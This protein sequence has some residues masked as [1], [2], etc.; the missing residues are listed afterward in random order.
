MSKR[1]V[2]K[3]DETNLD[4]GFTVTVIDGV[5]RPQCILCSKVFSNSSLKPSKLQEHFRNKHG[6]KES[7]GQ[8]PETL[9]MKKA[10]FDNKRTLLNL[11]KSRSTQDKQ[12]LHASHR[13]AYRIA[14]SKKPHTKAESL[15][16]PCAMDMVKIAMGDDAE[17]KLQQIPLSNDVISTR[18]SDISEDILDQVV[19]GIKASPVKIS[20]QL[21]ESTDVSNCSLLIVMV[22]YVKDK[23]VVEDFLFCSS[24]KTTTTAIDVFELVQ[25]FSSKNGIDLVMIGSACTD[26]APKMLGNHS[27]FAALMKRE[28]PT[29]QVTHCFCTDTL[30]LQ[31][32]RQQG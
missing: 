14:K 2:R 12:L 13:V 5:E 18:I 15:I 27:G 20:I 30:S 17:K 22:R 16:K 32:L 21:D 25:N 28:I 10:R 8:D 24:L 6:G 1:K 4:F 3:W 29:L 26:G 23:S 19:S 31:R 11:M 7:E 9:K